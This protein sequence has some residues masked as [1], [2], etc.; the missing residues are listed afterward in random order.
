MKLHE[1]LCELLGSRNVYFA[2][3][4]NIQMRYPCMLYD[5]EN[6]NTINADDIRYLHRTRITLTVIDTDP[7]SD[8][9]NRL[10][11]SSFRYLAHDRTYIA[12]GLYHFVFTL[13]V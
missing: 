4:S 9:P 7:D 6:T 3:P 5:V 12:D 2:G 1:E 13:Y 10:M 8:I 11:E